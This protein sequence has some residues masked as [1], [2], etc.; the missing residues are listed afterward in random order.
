MNI[1]AK[2]AVGTGAVARI[3]FYLWPLSSRKW[4]V[5]ISGLLSLKHL[6]GLEWGD[7]D[8]ETRTET[9]RDAETQGWVERVGGDRRRKRENFPGFIKKTVENDGS[10][11]GVISSGL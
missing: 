2:P 10:P 1:S 6:R 5:S 8:R 7:R 11:G 9:Q 3:P 4:K